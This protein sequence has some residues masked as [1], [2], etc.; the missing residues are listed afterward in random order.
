MGARHVVGV[1]PDVPGIGEVEGELVVL[2]VVLAHINVVSV[3]T[4][5]VERLTDRRAGAPLG[6]VVARAALAAG[7]V[8]SFDQ[9]A[10][11][12][13]LADLREVPLIGGKIQRRADALEVLDLGLDLRG[14]GG[15]RLVGPLELGIAVKILLGVLLRRQRRVER[16]A[17]LLAGI[18]VIQLAALGPGRDRVAVGV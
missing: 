2:G 8:V 6:L 11:L 17:E 18:I 3:G 16:H 10:V 1:E 4:D 7:V 9:S 5:V 13:L 12:E 14:Q 15:Q